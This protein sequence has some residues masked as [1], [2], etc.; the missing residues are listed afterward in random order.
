MYSILQYLHF[1]GDPIAIKN[2]KKCDDVFLL[3]SKIDAKKKELGKKEG[4][5]GKRSR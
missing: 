5:E 4:K 1:L 3:R 2:F